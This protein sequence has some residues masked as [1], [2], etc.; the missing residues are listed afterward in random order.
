MG[1]VLRC[2]NTSLHFTFRQWS[3]LNQLLCKGTL[4]TMNV[5]S[6]SHMGD[7]LHDVWSFYLFFMTHMDTLKALGIQG[8]IDFIGKSNLSGKYTHENCAEILMTIDIIK[9]NMVTSFHVESLVK[10]LTHS[11][12][13]QSHLYVM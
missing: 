11:T 2:N 9:P 1:I 6:D 4:Q 13:T 7:S 12:N 5:C 3:S 10:L 8:I